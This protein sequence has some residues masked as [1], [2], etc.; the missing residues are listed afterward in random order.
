VKNILNKNGFPLAGLVLLLGLTLCYARFDRTAASAPAGKADVVLIIDA[1]HGGTDGGA[2]SFHSHRESRINLEIARRTEQL[3][4]FAGVCCVMTRESEELSYPAD[5][6]TIHEKKV[7]DT[8]RRTEQINDT[9]NAVLL[10][11]HQNQYSS[12]TVT[13]AQVLYA[14]T[15]LSRQLAETLQ[16]V[17]AQKLSSGQNR[18]ASQISEDIYIMNH[19]SCPAVL[20]ECG[21]LSSPKE[22]ELLLSASYQ[23]RL[24]AAM[25]SA[26]LQNETLFIQYYNG[27]SV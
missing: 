4:A 2:V 6:D 15:D 20:A 16:S 8:Q 22:E 18:S 9:E 11:I 17:F 24:S 19:I 14:K 3:A 27:E 25:V 1:G 10:S 26:Y 21:F 7:Y 23:I 12:E 13:G 5:A